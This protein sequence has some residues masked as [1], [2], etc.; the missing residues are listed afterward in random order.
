MVSH[1]CI[2]N[3]RARLSSTLMVLR[4][5]T[6][7]TLLIEGPHHSCGPLHPPHRRLYV[8]YIGIGSTET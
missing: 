1:V 4:C 2:W 6:F 5:A 7:D 8:Y 3:V